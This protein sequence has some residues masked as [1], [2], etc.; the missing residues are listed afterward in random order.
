MSEKWLRTCSTSGFFELKFLPVGH[1]GS[2]MM[3]E[4]DAEGNAG[5]SL[6][7]A[8]PSSESVRDFIHE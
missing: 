4:I 8:P 6:S 7:A 3:F 5:M 1:R 2:D